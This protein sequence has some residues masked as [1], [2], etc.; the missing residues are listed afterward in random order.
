MNLRLAKYLCAALAVAT[1]TGC[2]SSSDSVNTAPPPTTSSTQ[3]PTTLPGQGK[4]TVTIG[5]KNY[6]EEFNLGELYYEALQAQGFPVQI[7]QNI[8][9]TSVTLQ[10]L[11]SGQLG[12]YPEYLNVWDSQVA[13]LTRQFR[14]RHAAYV[15]GNR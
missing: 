1:I 11:A 12:M 3:V 9:A 7:N 14:T 13:G 8:G 2:D 10:A 15:A 4:P 6:T 5:D